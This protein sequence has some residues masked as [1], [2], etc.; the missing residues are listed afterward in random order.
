MST[1]YCE[2]CLT[3]ENTYI[4][5]G[6]L[7]IVLP[8]QPNIGFN[9]G[10]GF[11]SSVSSVALQSDGK[12]LV[13]GFFTSYSGVARNYII[14]LNTDGSV[15]NS[16]VIGTGFNSGVVDIEVQTD[17]KILVIG[18]FTSYSGVAK[19]YI[20]RLNTNGSIDNSF[21]I[22]SSFNYPPYDLELQTDGKILVGGYFTI[23]SG[24]SVGVGLI[25]LNTNGSRD[26][27][28][29]IGSGFYSYFGEG[30]DGT[31][32][33]IQY[34]SDGKIIVGGVFT[35]YNG[36][37]I[38]SGIVRLTS[39]GTIDSTFNNGSGVGEATVFSIKLQ[40]D[41]KVLV[42][43]N[44][45]EYSGVSNNYIVRLDSN[46]SIDTSFVIGTGFNNAVY[47]IELQSD[48]KILVVGG[49]TSYSGVARNYIIRLNTDGSVDTSFVIGTGF[50]ASVE[51]IAV[52]SNGKIIVGGA[53]TRFNGYLN[54]LICQL[55]SLSINNPILYSTDFRCYEALSEAFNNINPLFD[56][57]T[58][59]DGEVNS[60]VIDSDGKILVGG[61]FGLYSG[62][63][64]NKIIRLNTNYTIDNSFVI[65]TGFN[66]SVY[67]I[68]L[69]SDGK[70]LVGGG[71]TSY[72]G[73][74]RNG[75][76]RLNT[77]GSVDNSFVIGTGFN[78]QVNTIELQSDGKILVGGFFSLYSGVSKNYIVRL[79]SNGSIDTSFVIGTGFNNLV[80]DILVQSD[81]K[82]LV[83]GLFPSYSGVS[84]NG[85]VRLNTDGSIDSSFVTGN[86]FTGDTV[87]NTVKIQT[88]GKIL[89]GGG[90]TSYSGVSKN[91]IIRLNSN[92]SIDTSF[93]IGTGFNGNVETITLQS[94]G[95]ILVGGLFTVYSGVS[96]NYI[97][98]LNTDGSVDNS[99][100]VGTGFNSVV[101]KITLQSGGNILVGG[102]FTEIANLNAYKFIELLGVPFESEYTAIELFT[103][104]EICNGY[105]IPISANTE[106]IDCLICN[107][108]ALLVDA[109]HPVWTG[110][111][112]GVVTQ[113]DAVTIGG[114]GWNS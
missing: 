104:C 105:V 8:G 60:I 100:V 92:G 36:T 58:G 72:S 27:T 55:D 96:N 56:I 49:F 12:I 51:S 91:R 46:G 86:G 26:N 87:V 52:N 67:G 10:S 77:D 113:M 2:S 9:I 28:L 3:G 111:N 101:Y 45:T 70:I 19:N 65:G 75:I 84:K 85:I 74:S 6:D 34:Q 90:F 68:E 31:V 44:F 23:Y 109:P 29:N 97:V 114:N 50:N 102:I 82:I 7:P 66:Y 35:D 69:Q 1:Y 5:G 110:L 94:D 43:G 73:V 61:G 54:N 53:F 93:V 98:R 89:V 112:G 37:S 63:P 4:D 15:D 59:F 41:G 33:T 88:D 71:F 95:K 11:N 39:G 18:G 38:G 76:I 42:G 22:G 64:I 80:K 16:F 13:G 24:V 81:G 57:G 47:D 30:G 78:S 108:D 14:R 32:Y 103:D 48:G 20:I 106:Y 21:S 99:F 25:R 40:S 79:N 83:V 17:G 62:I 107:G